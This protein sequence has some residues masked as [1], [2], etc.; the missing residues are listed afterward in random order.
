MTV[1]INMQQQLL[2]TSPITATAQ[3]TLFA[4]PS[5]HIIAIIPEYDSLYTYAIGLYSTYTPV[6]FL[7]R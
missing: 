4:Q 1:S 2:N 5:E 6:N 7:Y 3:K